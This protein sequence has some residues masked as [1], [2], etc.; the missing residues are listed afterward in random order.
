MMFSF[1]YSMLG[2]CLSGQIEYAVGV[3]LGSWQGM[4]SS[5]HIVAKRIKIPTLHWS[6]L[7]K[8][9]AEYTGVPDVLS[10]SDCRGHIMKLVLKVN[11]CLVLT[12]RY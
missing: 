9:F 7:A 4:S 10:L 6:T 3:K 8:D 2:N 1:F 12:A 11:R 5:I